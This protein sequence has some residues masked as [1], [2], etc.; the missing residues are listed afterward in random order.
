MSAGRRISLPLEKS[1]IP[2]TLIFGNLFKKVLTKLLP[3][4]PAHPVTRI[5]LLFFSIF[6]VLNNFKTCLQAPQIIRKRIGKTHL[7]NFIHG[8]NVMSNHL[9]FWSAETQEHFVSDFGEIRQK[10]GDVAGKVG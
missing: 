4:K 3:I 9:V 10:L 6:L 7:Q 1:S 2:A 5:V 8:L